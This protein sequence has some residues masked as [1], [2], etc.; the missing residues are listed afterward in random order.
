MANVKILHLLSLEKTNVENGTRYS[1]GLPKNCGCRHYGTRAGRRK[2]GRTCF[3]SHGLKRMRANLSTY[4]IF[5]FD[6]GA[7]LDKRCRALNLCWE[8]YNF[9][10]SLWWTDYCS[11]LS[12][13]SFNRFWPSI[14]IFSCARLPTSSIY[15]V[16]IVHVDYMNMIITCI[17][18]PVIGKPKCLS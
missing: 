4:N 18:T 16:R 5:V 2:Q 13:L 14:E 9:V 11:I 15:Q 8:V 7:L 17:S 3:L 12:C 10:Y 1:L 6:K